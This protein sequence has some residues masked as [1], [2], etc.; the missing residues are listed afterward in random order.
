MMGGRRV[1]EVPTAVEHG[2]GIG[3]P[4]DQPPPARVPGRGLG[5]AFRVAGP[6][7]V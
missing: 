3:L 5:V 2:A 1:I 4:V 6:E 7:Q